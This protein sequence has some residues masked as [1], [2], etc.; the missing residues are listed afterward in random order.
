MGGR[1]FL[2]RRKNILGNGEENVRVLPKDMNIKDFLRVAQ[3][4]VR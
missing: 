3:T 1:P 2:F 4:E